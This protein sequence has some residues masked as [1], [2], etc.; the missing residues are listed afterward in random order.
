MVLWPV[1]R[2]GRASF[3]RD[4]KLTSLPHTRVVALFVL[5]CFARIGEASNPG[6]PNADFAAEFVLGIANPTGL[7]NK[8]PYVASQ[9][10]HG[11]VWMFSETHL[12]S[13]GCNPST[14]V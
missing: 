3:H 13:R 6:P 7:R 11:D 9:M 10:A 12:S 8:G 2:W 14:P 4:A 5:L 1:F